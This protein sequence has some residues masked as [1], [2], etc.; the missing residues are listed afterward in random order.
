M[1]PGRWLCYSDIILNG[2]LFEFYPGLFGHVQ[3]RVYLVIFNGLG[4]K[5]IQSEGSPF[6]CR[7]KN[8]TFVTLKA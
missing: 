6:K 2:D 5:S 4:K 8:T 1:L 7:F 3:V